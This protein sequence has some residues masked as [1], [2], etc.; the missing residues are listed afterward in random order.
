MRWEAVWIVLRTVRSGSWLARYIRNREQVNQ[1][2]DALIRPFYNTRL[3]AQRAGIF[4]LTPATN[5]SCNV[6]IAIELRTV[7]LFVFRSWQALSQWLRMFKTLVLNFYGVL[8]LPRRST[9]LTG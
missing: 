7:P 1:A 2:L 4:A 3:L 8:M 9:I 5:C 6:R